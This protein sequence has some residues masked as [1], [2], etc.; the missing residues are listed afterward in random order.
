MKAKP[1]KLVKACRASLC[2]T[3]LYSLGLRQIVKYC[4]TLFTEGFVDPGDNTPYGAW[5]WPLPTRN[6]PRRTSYTPIRANYSCPRCTSWGNDGRIY[7]ARLMGFQ[8]PRVRRHGSVKGS[9][10]LSMESKHDKAQ[11]KDKEL[12]TLEP[13]MWTLEFQEERLQNGNH[14]L[15]RL[16]SCRAARLRSTPTE[17]IDE[18]GALMDTCNVP[19]TNPQLK[20]VSF[21]ELANDLAIEQEGNPLGITT[22]SESELVSIP[23]QFCAT[24]RGRGRGPR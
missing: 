14:R 1:S 6:Q 8:R 22:T 18:N 17:G 11:H 4:E 9:S 2:A 16:S 21:G 5:L 19:E 24:V 12:E 10:L 23:L 3:E 20:V 15:P 13:T 7:L